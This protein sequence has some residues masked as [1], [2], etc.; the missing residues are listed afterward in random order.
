[1]MESKNSSTFLEKILAGMFFFILRYRP[2]NDGKYIPDNRGRY[3]RGNEGDYKHIEGKQG[4][5][6][7]FGGIGGVGGFGGVGGKGG[8][9]GVGG[10]GRDKP[11][12]S[13]PSLK[14]TSEIRPTLKPTNSWFPARFPVT[15]LADNEKPLYYHSCG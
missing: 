4:G 10:K 11:I 3:D 7:G 5:A 1:M 13:L 14:D 2:S 6:G 15:K 9:G 8:A 12:L